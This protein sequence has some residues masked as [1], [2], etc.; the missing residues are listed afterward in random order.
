MNTQPQY[1]ETELI[2][3]LK[4][5]MFFRVLF[6]TLLLGSTIILQLGQTPSPLAKPLLYL[7]GIIAFIFVLS[8]LY[9]IVMGRIRRKI[10]FA[11]IQVF[12]DTFIVSAIIFLTGS[13]SSLFSFLYLIVIIYA[14]ILLYRKGSMWV[15]S[16]CSI[17][18]GIMID[19]E[20]YGF[21]KPLGIEHN[22][23]IV[24]Y[25]M[26]HVMYKIVIMI[27]SCFAVAFLSSLLAEQVRSTK[28]DLVAMEDQVKRVEKMA[29]VGEMA[30]RMAHEIKNPIA[31][32]RGSIQMMKEDVN[33]DPAL[34]RLMH[35]VLREADRLSSLVGDFLVF[36]R[37][38]TGKV[39]TVNLSVSLSE[40]IELFKNS[41]ECS[42]KVVIKKQ[43]QDD[44]WI[45]IDPSHLRQIFW[46]LM[47]NAAESISGK[48]VIEI[49]MYPQRN[50]YTFI[51]ISDTGCGIS[52]EVINSIFDPFFTTKQNGTGL[53]LSIVHRILESYD[54]RMDVESEIG[55]GTTFT[56]KMRTVD[57]TQHA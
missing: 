31:S 12:I 42:G 35:I 23:I 14:S 47:L 49:K 51:K 54:S 46:N 27:I 36:A 56:I 16:I 19:L 38:P 37:P 22:L 11:Y 8:F 57:Q 28:R 21:L 34:D 26:S 40:L 13:F 32:L 33:K 20:F 30:S 5:I 41:A 6:T 44:I 1:P 15:A 39:E 9:G 7:Y 48:G 24:D 25:S 17:Q 55:K 52:Q 50:R 18:Y 45:Q 53:G 4:W 3:K 43:L 10:L 29:A 2:L